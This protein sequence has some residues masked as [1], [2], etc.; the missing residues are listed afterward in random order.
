[1]VVLNT[2]ADEGAGF[3]TDTNKVTILNSRGEE[4]TFPLKSKREVATDIV[5]SIMRYRKG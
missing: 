2:L 3:G 4:K 5:D 1:M